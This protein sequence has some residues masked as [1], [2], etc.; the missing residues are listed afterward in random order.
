MSI[1]V[2]KITVFIVLLCVI[3]IIG[4]CNDTFDIDASQYASMSREMLSSGDFLHVHDHGMEYLDKPPFLFW[5]NSLSMRI[6]GIN[7]FGHGFASFLFSLTAVFSTFKFC[8]LFYSKQ[9]SLLAAVILATSQ[10]FFVM[11]QDIRTDTILMS[12][13]IFSIWQLAAWYQDNKGYH[14]LLACVGIAGGL[15]TKGPIAL[16]VPVFAF[17][18]HYFL[19]RNW[20]VF[21]RWE[22]LVGCAIILLLLLPMCIGLY[23]QF[24]QHPEKLV[25][26]KHEVSGLRFFFWTQSFGRITGESDWNNHAGFFFLLQN[27]LWSFLPWILFFLIALGRNVRQ[28]IG[29]KFKLLPGQEWISTGG[30]LLTYVSLGLSKYQLP[31]YIF[32][33]FPLA[34]VVTANFLYQLVTSPGYAKW[35]KALK[36]THIIIFSLLGSGLVFLMWYCFSQVAVAVVALALLLVFIFVAFYGKFRVPSLLVLCVFW[37]TGANFFLNFSINPTLL[38]YQMGNTAGR[39]IHQNKVP[40]NAVFLYKYGHSWSLDFYAQANIPS[41]DS[42]DQI[43]TG[44]WVILHVKD[45]KDLDSAGR[46]YQ[47]EY[48]NVDFHVSMLTGKFLNP[49]TR[50]EVVAPYAIIRL[51]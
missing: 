47:V 5:M 51:L 46:K 28:I 34:A 7:N 26:G 8:R 29:Q 10:G 15:M 45:L 21:L 48:H 18:S 44:D 4:F 12:W 27:M 19:Q 36:L 1:M 6:F 33:V 9:I 37:I 11:N 22:Y 20:K 16:F 49:S 25:N 14:F 17:G 2:R 3:Y 38:T 50:E 41:R 30:F 32:V 35:E 31:H 42:L 13:V 23:Q 24:D 43:R 39:W 40:A